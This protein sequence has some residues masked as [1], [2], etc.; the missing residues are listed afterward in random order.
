MLIIKD[1]E[2][3]NGI[4][5]E[6][7]AELLV[8]T[9]G[10]EEDEAPYKS[11][12]EKEGFT[13]E[14]WMIAKKEWSSRMSDPADNGK[15]TK[16]FL[17]LY[18]TAIERKYSEKEPCSIETFTKI[19]CEITFRR[20]P[21]DHTKKINYEIILK[22]HKLTVARWGLY[23]SFWMPRIATPEYSDKFAE[24]VQKNAEKILGIYD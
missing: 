7:Y 1:K 8:K 13:M 14:N 16:L 9:I 3:I 20:D 10:V 17:P 23:N 12:I 24:L 5:L 19:H 11:I 2:K 15:T 21:E 22:E 6:K 18:Q 4:S